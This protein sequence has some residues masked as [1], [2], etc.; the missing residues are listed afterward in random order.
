MYERNRDRPAATVIAESR[1]Q[2]GQMRAAVE[3]V[4]EADLIEP[5]RFDWLDG[6]P[7]S[8]VLAGSFEHLHE[9]HEPAIRAWLANA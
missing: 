6:A 3:A 1:E 7:L 5:G 8:A 4:P 2:F 9:E